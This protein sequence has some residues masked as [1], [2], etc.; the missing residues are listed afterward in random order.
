MSDPRSGEDVA[1]Y[2]H[3]SEDLVLHPKGYL[4]WPGRQRAPWT[5]FALP[6]DRAGDAKAYATP[7]PPLVL[8]P[9]HGD[10]GVVARIGRATLTLLASPAAIAPL[11]GGCYAET[12][13]GFFVDD[14]DPAVRI[15]LRLPFGEPA[16]VLVPRGEALGVLERLYC[17][18][19]P[20]G[21]T[22]RPI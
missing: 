6:P 9:L 10:L 8:A 5:P 16:E 7:A 22:E 15:G 17:A 11:H 12:Y 2:N 13:G 3:R 18:V 1:R 14:R 4:H 20:V 21:Y 19:A